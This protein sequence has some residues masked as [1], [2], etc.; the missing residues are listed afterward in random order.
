MN[1]LSPSSIE[2]KIKEIAAKA[3]SILNAVITPAICILVILYRCASKNGL[4]DKASLPLEQC[5]GL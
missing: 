5:L 3:P 1:Y 4:P 2:C